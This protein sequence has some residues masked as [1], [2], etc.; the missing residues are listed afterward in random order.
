[1]PVEIVKQGE[2]EI[3]ETARFDT[4]GKIIIG[5]G[6]FVAHEVYICTHIHP[7]KDYLHWRQMAPETVTLEIGEW[8]F[9][10]SRAIILP[11]VGKI[12]TGAIIGA[13]SVVTKEVPA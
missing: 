10:G 9:I 6:T 4:R 8:V 5:N 11:Q 13:G 1:M 2:V 3:K 7:V 12:G